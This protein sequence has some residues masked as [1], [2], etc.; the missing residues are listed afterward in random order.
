MASNAEL[1]KLIEEAATAAG[2]DVPDTTGKNNGQL[3]EILSTIKQAERKQDKADKMKD[4]SAKADAEAKNPEVEKP[5]YELAKGKS[6]TTKKGIIGE[7]K[8][9]KAEYLAGGK[10]ALD[11][12]VEKGYITDNT[13]N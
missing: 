1:I 10:D 5:D 6:L 11:A 7:G 2:V 9:I 8:E 3:S 4:S 13:A 12:L